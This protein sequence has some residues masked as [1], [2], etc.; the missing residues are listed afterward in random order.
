MKLLITGGAGYI[1]SHVVL[2]ALNHGFEVTIFDD[3]STGCKDNIHPKAKFFNGSTCSKLDLAELFKNN[4]FD[5][6]I[7][8][9]ARKAAG[10]SMT[11]PILYSENNIVGSLNLINACHQ[12]RVKFFIFSSTAAIYGEPKYIPIDEKHPISPV[13]Y[14]GY[15][16]LV[17]EEN[18]KWF[19]SL[20][21]MR[22]ASLRYFNA[23]GYDINGN[24]SSIE[25]NPQNLIPIVMEAALGV[26][27][28]VEIF[29]NNFGTKDG[30]G[31][32]DY[33]HVSDLARAHLDAINYISNRNENIIVNLG[34][35]KG[36]SVLEII[37][38]V[39]DISGINLRYTVVDKRI[40]DPDIVIAEAKLAENLIGWDGY[41]SNL[42]SI[43]QSTWDI[44]KTKLIN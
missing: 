35:G 28:K 32:R 36:H 12:N 21:N 8:L 20:N 13:N 2:A 40:G 30:T 18:L 44:Y 15:T 17:I 24:V 43:I 26:R 7:H 31:I 27:S 1:G 29:G 9:A 25:I 22:Y 38:K 39:I 41:N 37:N 19:S 10:E 11:K 14:Y 33:V 5:C 16:K 4:N 6:V 34:T 23:A 3:L 42:D